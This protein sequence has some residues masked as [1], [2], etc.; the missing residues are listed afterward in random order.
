MYDQTRNDWTNVCFALSAEAK[1]VFEAAT[2]GFRSVKYTPCAFASQ[3]LAGTRYSFLC[4]A[5]RVSD[6]PT[7]HAVKIRIFQPLCSLDAPIEVKPII[8]SIETITP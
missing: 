8:V 6:S 3:A 5:Q 7:S 4:E 2:A 1:R